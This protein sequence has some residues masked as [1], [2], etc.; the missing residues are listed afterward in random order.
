MKKDKTPLAIRFVRWAYPKVEKIF[1][2]LAHRYFIH[3]FYTPFHYTPPESEK[4]FMKTAKEFSITVGGKYIQCYRWGESGP[5]VL[6]V[7]GWAGR[8]GQFRKIIPALLAAGFQV[9]AFDGPAHGKSEG[10]QTDFLEFCQV[11]KTIEEKERPFTGVIAHSFGGV[12]ML[13]AAAMGLPLH[14]LIM[15]STPTIG[16]QV[17]GNYRHAINASPASGEYFAQ[18][19]IRKYGRP[20]DEYAALHLVSHLPAPLDL[21]AIQDEDDRDVHVMNATELKKAYPAARI[22]VTKGLGHTRILKDDSVIA[23]CVKHLTNRGVY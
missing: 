15:I 19:H 10:K 2:A 20:F 3:V 12:A 13:N 21:L 23:L 9:V 5:K 17:V 8:A 11:F 7:H 16:S 18:Y 22:H 6:L 1:P 4:T 14:R